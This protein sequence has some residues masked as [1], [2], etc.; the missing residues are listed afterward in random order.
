[1]RAWILDSVGQ[2]L[3]SAEAPEPELRGGGVIVEVRA[4][5]LPAYTAA[6]AGGGRGAIPTPL[7]LGP[8]CVGV[9]EAVADDVFN[10][11]PG[12][13]VV[14]NSLLGSGD[15]DEPEEILVGWTGVG[16][17]GVPTETTTAMQ[18]VWRDGVWAERALCP[19]ETLVRLPGAAARPRPEKLAFLPWLAI[20]A[21][22][23]NRAGLRAGQTVV[24]VGATGQLGGAAVL[25]ALARGA[26]SVVAVGRNAVALERLA[27]VDPRVRTVASTGDRSRDAAAIG[28]ADVV[29]DALGAVPD[30]GP[31]LTGYDCLRTG[32]T[33]VLV[34]GVKQDLPLPYG[35]LMRRRL[36]VRGSFMYPHAAVAEVWRM[37]A[38]GTLNLDA[39]EA[40]TVGLDDPAGALDLAAKTTGLDF[41]ALVP[42]AR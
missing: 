29:L 20:A 4:A 6:L 27:A 37:V 31:T 30:A 7:L 28:P 8:S 15:A 14:A 22:G 24:V 42:A 17:H 39:V 18:E 21:E 33:M 9:V 38:C 13:F 2:A 10:V 32:G 16:A 36:T 26:A 3:R 34:G 25:V 5:H 40:L 23:L 12:D 35:D 11:A 1:M 19:K 41:V